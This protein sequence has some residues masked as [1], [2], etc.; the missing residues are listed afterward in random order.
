MEANKA[1]VKSFS[2]K[3]SR[4]LNDL[5]GA[6]DRL[7]N[8]Q[9]NLI[10]KAFDIK[11]LGDFANLQD[12][13]SKKLNGLEH[14]TVDTEGV[15]ALLMRLINRDIEAKEWILNVLA[16]LGQKDVNKW[17]DS[18]VDHAENRLIDFSKRIND[19]ER[20]KFYDM[21]E[22]TDPMSE[23]Y[24]IRSTKKGGDIKDGLIAISPSDKDVLDAI[25]QKISS[26]LEEL[27]TDQLKLSALTKIIDSY[28]KK[29][30]A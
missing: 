11:F 24:L 26:T 12:A 13:V 1:Q 9:A 19:L 23:I 15:R 29:I 3:L 2:V 22:H 16:Y 18:D 4:A 6:Q 27:S 14:H 28:L 7:L 8:K 30:E 10:G 5:I 21:R 20:L 25:S 17:T